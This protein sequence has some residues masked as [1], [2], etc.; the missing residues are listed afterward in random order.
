MYLFHWGCSRKFILGNGMCY[1]YLIY[2]YII[3]I[4]KGREF[5]VWYILDVDRRNGDREEVDDEKRLR[6]KEFG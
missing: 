1:I 2:I 6:I 5:N 4:E 3:Y